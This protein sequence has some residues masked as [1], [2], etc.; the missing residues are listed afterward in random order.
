MEFI[1]EFLEQK[2]EDCHEAKQ[3]H[4]KVVTELREEF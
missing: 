1:N 3:S 4:E 2:N